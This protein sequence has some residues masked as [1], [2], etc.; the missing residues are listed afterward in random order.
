MPLL[1]W[2]FGGGRSYVVHGL[3]Y[4][5]TQFK[6]ASIEMRD[7]RTGV[8]TRLTIIGVLD[9]QSYFG[10]GICT[11]ASTLAAAH[12][13]PAPPAVYYMRVAPGQDVH[14]VAKALGSA[15]LTNGL[16]VVE[17]RVE[18][19][20]D[21]SIGSGMNYLLEG[22]MALGLVVGI[23][24]IAAVTNSARLLKVL[25]PAGLI[26]SVLRGMDK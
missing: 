3:N 7:M 25:V 13:A 23:A 16:D 9:Q 1:P 6:P 24:C 14:A 2:F 18:Y 22:F 12:D 26:G 4:K 10:N 15:F 11:G 5:Q 17:T 19:A 8:T 20:T 21:Q